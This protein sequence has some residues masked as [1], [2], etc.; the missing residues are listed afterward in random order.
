M[1]IDFNVDVNVKTN[2]KDDVDALEKQIQRLQ[3]TKLNLNVSLS[4]NGADITSLFSGIEK[5]AKVAGKSVGNS[6][7]KGFKAVKFNGNVDDFYKQYLDQQKKNAKEAE[8]ISKQYGVSQKEAARVVNAKN[9]SVVKA[10]NDA[11][12]EQQKQA[13]KLAK[14]QQNVLN[15]TYAAKSSSLTSKLS[16]YSNQDTELVKQAKEQAKLYDDTLQNL[17]KHYDTNDLFKLN[18]DEVV[19]SFETMNNAAKKFDNTMTQI[20]NTQSKDLGLGVAERSANSVRAYYESNTKA[21]K[22]YGAELKDLESRYRSIKTE[23]EKLNLDNDFKNLKAKISAEGLTGKSALEELGRGF[24][25]IGEFAWTYGLIQQ[26]PN[27][28]SQSVNELKQID[29]IITEISKAADVPVKQLKELGN[30]SFDVASKYGQK[31]SDYLLGV[32][33]MTRAGYSDTS[34]MA[35]LSTLA[36]SAGDMT[37][38]LA[39]QYLIASDMAFGYGGN[40][41]KLNA[42]LDSQNQITNRNAVNM[43]E[44]ANAT[45][46]VA[47]QAAQSGVAEDQMT[48]ALSTMIATTQQGGEIAARAFKGILMNLQQVTGELDDGE[49]IDEAKLQKVEKRLTGVGVAMKEIKDGTVSLRDPMQVLEELAQVYNSLPDNSVEKAGIISDLGGKIYLVV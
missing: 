23:A 17:K 46:I 30:N 44:L 36:Q 11:L 8:N 13:E 24:K 16:P 25:R 28:L 35:E 5:Q 1:G 47:S 37:A 22:K 3:N 20:R 26:I 41:E 42:L 43:T 4:G 49:V 15:G 7:Q 31:A 40:V 32:Q 27:A 29:T 14:I 19:K 34:G 45:K 6:F 38:E 33:E 18:D 39:N 9:N 12:K 10:N 21:I 2:G 48:A